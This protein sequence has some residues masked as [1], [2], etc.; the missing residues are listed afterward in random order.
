MAGGSRLGHRLESANLVIRGLQAG[1]QGALTCHGGGELGH[2]CPAEVVHAGERDRG[3][4]PAGQPVGGVQHAG[5]LDRARDQVPGA[6][7]G[8]LPGLNGPQNG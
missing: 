2:V 1:Q 5:V 3:A 8:G 7:G 4:G 6:T